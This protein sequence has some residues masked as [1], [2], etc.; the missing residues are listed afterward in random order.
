LTLFNQAE[1][2]KAFDLDAFAWEATSR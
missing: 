2:K 1:M